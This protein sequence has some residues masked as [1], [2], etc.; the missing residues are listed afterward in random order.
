MFQRQSQH[1]LRHLEKPVKASRRA[2]N[3]ELPVK[4]AALAP[5][6]RSPVFCQNGVLRKANGA[7]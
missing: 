5:H 7:C 2:R 3:V 6:S 1:L 4:F